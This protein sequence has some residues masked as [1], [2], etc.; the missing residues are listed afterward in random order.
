MD[1]IQKIFGSALPPLAV[2]IIGAVASVVGAYLGGY[3]SDRALRREKRRAARHAPFSLQD[4]KLQT[5]MHRKHDPPIISL[6]C[7]D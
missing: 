6:D 1:S 4:F 2:L 7:R 5:S 3:L